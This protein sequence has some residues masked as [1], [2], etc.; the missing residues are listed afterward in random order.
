MNTPGAPPPAAGN[1]VIGYNEAMKK[2]SSAGLGRAMVI[3]AW[4]L[5]IALLSLFFNRW[6]DHQRNP[7]RE[8]ASRITTEGVREIQ[9]QQNRYGHYVMTGRINGRDVEFLLD[10]GA[11]TISIPSG[12]ANALQLEKGFPYQ[13]STANGTIT[14]YSTQ[15]QSLE[16]GDIVLHKVRAHINPYME[17]DDILLGMTALKDLEII[18][19]DRVLT[20]RQRAA[21]S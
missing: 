6:L 7:N 2:H 21:G 4:V 17:G 8:F 5:V 13:V 18:Q 19:R 3:G 14:V 16:L 11:T 10:T 15:L 12:V 20:L 1:T 9:L